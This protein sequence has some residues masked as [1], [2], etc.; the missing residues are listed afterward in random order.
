MMS[1]LHDCS[2]HPEKSNLPLLCLQVGPVCRHLPH[3][4]PISGLWKSQA[5]AMATSPELPRLLSSPEDQGR[6]PRGQF[7][8]NCHTKGKSQLH[9][10]PAGLKRVIGLSLIWQTV[11][12]QCYFG[13][14]RDFLCCLKGNAH[15]IASHPPPL[16]VHEMK[17]MF[18]LVGLSRFSSHLSED[19]NEIKGSLGQFLQPDS[20]QKA[21]L[22]LFQI[23]WK[24]LLGPQASLSSASEP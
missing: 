11:C 14:R 18:F 22:Q 6:E 19:V 21:S 20:G 7:P 3:P 13:L 8:E 9:P 15:R 2:Q 24:L 4:H 12:F 1:S 16:S 5:E 23:L 17:I 10:H